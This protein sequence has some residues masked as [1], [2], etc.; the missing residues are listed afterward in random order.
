MT[1]PSTLA[2]AD[3]F[4]PAT[5]EQW[6]EL[7]AGVLRKS[8]RLPEDHTGPVEELL[9]TR[10]GDGVTI[11]PLYTAEDAPE[12]AGVPGVD[13]FVRGAR[14]LGA[15]PD[16]WDLRQRHADPDQAATA[17]AVLA[18]LENGVTSLWLVLGEGAL[19]PGSLPT[20]LADVLLDMAPIALDAGPEHTEAAARDLV[21]LARRR[22]VPGDA[23][24]GVLGA[25][26]FGWLAGRDAELDVDAALRTAAEL[27]GRCARDW[28]NLRAISVDATPVH[29]A[30]AEDAQELAYSLAAGVA[31]LRALTE[32]GLS[33]ADALRQ[34][35]FRYAA[36][37]DQ[38]ATIAKLRAARGLWARVARECGV[39][40]EQAAQRQHVVGSEV[41]VTARDPWVNMLR[42][43]LACFGAGVGGADSVTVPPF[44]AALGL[45]DP[46][47]RRIARNTQSLLIAESH[48]ARVVDPAG[49][50][51]YV[52]RLTADLAR[53]AWSAF[54]EIERAGG[55]ATAL[56]DGSLA[57]ALAATWGKRERRLATRKE[58]VLGVSEFP[59]LTEKLPNRTPD[60]RPAPRGL[61]PRVR[62][63]AAFE[64]LRDR[65]DAHVAATGARPGVFLATLG[66]A[67]SAT[68]RVGFATNLFQA[69]GLDTPS[70]AGTPEELAAAFAEAGTPV[71]C[72]CG[73]DPS[74]AESAGPVA[75]ALRTAGA[76]KVILAGKPGTSTADGY[77]FAG[78]DAVEVLTA[79]LDE[80]GVAK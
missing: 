69:G 45:P 51:W 34:L 77:V 27:A 37:A 61:L 21:D 49:G 59:N 1:Q 64:A 66:S 6:R 75:E 33:T 44:D 36:T 31:Y 79:V 35:E 41:M 28:P 7:I 19:P 71:A 39:T 25:D 5:R 42:G 67:A 53:R 62:R 16:G 48:L 74:Y 4:P 63:A 52:E 8:G 3:E 24:T 43:T 56:R 12:G 11:A 38:F 10:L 58:P 70:A 26:P 60:P 13:P 57:E 65:A 23:L 2:L 9:A 68:A 30:G 54:T 78:C 46:F 73:A 29:N 40:G 20:V 47:S 32:S 55:V 22:E 76:T 72:L 15:N 17:E 18:D 50:S 80:L 14:P